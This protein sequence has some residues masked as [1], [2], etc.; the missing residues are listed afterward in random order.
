MR[1]ERF[2]DWGKMSRIIKNINRD[3]AQARDMSL[4]RFVLFAEGGAKKHLRDQDLKWKP[5]NPQYLAAKVKRGGSGKI[6]IDTSTYFRDITGW[7]KNEMALVGIKRESKDKKGKPL[8]NIAR[9]HEFG[10]PSRNIPARPLWKP[11]LKESI[12]YIKKN[13]NPAVIYLELIEQKY[14]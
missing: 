8:A 14:K 3:L 7:V 1:V 13:G 4:K 12:T 5:L 11:V 9:L 10:S 6:L 2:G